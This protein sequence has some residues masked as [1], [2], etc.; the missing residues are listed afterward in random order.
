M[1]KSTEKNEIDSSVAFLKRNYPYLL[2]FLLMGLNHNRGVFQIYGP[3]FFSLVGIIAFRYFSNR[4]VA[5]TLRIIVFTGLFT[6]LGRAIIGILTQGTP[7]YWQTGHQNFSDL[8]SENFFERL[9]FPVYSILQIFGVQPIPGT[10][11]LSWH[12]IL[13]VSSLCI[14]IL[15]V[16]LPVIR[17]R[18]LEIW[19]ESNLA[20]QLMYFH[21]LF[22]VLVSFFTSIFAGSS[23][24]VRYSIPLAI[25][26]I[27]FVSLISF[28]NG[29][30]TKYFARFVAIL[31]VPIVFHS[32]TQLLVPSQ[33]NYLNS[34]NFK[35]SSYLV[36]ESLSYGYAGPWTDDVMT[37]P[38]YSN[39]RVHIS[40]IDVNPLRPHLHADKA[41][42][43]PENHVGKTFLAVP[44]ELLSPSDLS[45]IAGAMPISVRKIDRFMV[46]IFSYNPT[47]IVGML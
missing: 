3:V 46:Y 42:F 19:Q 37:I 40:L 13:I 25:S 33:N 44:S 12:G 6:I 27:F 9:A 45:L 7:Q 15:I 14:V 26:A 16:F 21:I 39:G 11:V 43:L 2:V 31:M 47:E 29:K 41:W 32:S 18:R 24:T 10:P 4:P 23:G 34:S 35:L 20:G 1:Y 28:K 38:F 8:N 17:T 22:F 30:L 5:P 36:G